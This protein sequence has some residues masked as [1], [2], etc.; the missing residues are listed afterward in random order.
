M[1]AVISTINSELDWGDSRLKIL[2]ALILTVKRSVFSEVLQ[3]VAPSHVE[4]C[5]VCWARSLARI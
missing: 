5:I 4:A 3:P 1:K 2:R